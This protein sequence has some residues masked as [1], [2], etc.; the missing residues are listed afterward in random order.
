MESLDTQRAVRACPRLGNR[1]GQDPVAAAVELLQQDQVFRA[2]KCRTLSMRGA[3]VW[4]RLWWG[5]GGV[6]SVHTLGLGLGRTGAGLG[7]IPHVSA[8]VQCLQGLEP[9][10]SPTSGTCFPCSGACGPLSVHKLF[11]YGPLR[12]PFLLVAVAVAGWLLLVVSGSGGAGYLF[13]VGSAANCMTGRWLG[14][15]RCLC[16]F[17]FLDVMTVHGDVAR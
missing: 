5:S 7:R 15:R 1:R 2:K 10:S 13:M 9:G 6:D 4:G 11:T 3:A 16:W 12:G 8:G 17:A 14:E